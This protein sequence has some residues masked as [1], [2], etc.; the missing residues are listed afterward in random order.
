[1]WGIQ[2]QNFLQWNVQWRNQFPDQLP[3]LH[4]EA[5]LFLIEPEEEPWVKNTSE[6]LDARVLVVA[7]NDVTQRM[8][9]TDGAFF[10]PEIFS[11]DTIQFFSRCPFAHLPFEQTRPFAQTYD[12]I[13]KGTHG[14]FLRHLQAYTQLLRDN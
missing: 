2:I 4:S 11:L 8:N 9:L 10:T 6:V 5:G 1:M 14:E 12:P 7:M 13:P 3:P